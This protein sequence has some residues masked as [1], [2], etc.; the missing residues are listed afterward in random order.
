MSKDLTPERFRCCAAKQQEIDR[1]REALKP[2]ANWMFEGLGDGHGD[3][4]VVI[5]Y[6]RPHGNAKVTWGDLRAA[7]SALECQATSGVT[8]DPVSAEGPLQSG[9]RGEAL[10][11]HL[12]ANVPD[13]ELWGKD[14]LLWRDGFSVTAGKR[15]Q[16][17]PH[18]GYQEVWWDACGEVLEF[19]P[20]HC[21]LY[22]LPPQAHSPIEEDR[23]SDE[24][25]G[26]DHIWAT[27]D[28][29]SSLGEGCA[30]CGIARSALEGSK[31]DE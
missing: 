27:H 17:G 5:S 21:R 7:R 11:W 29:D 16:L 19:D 8:G 20:T 6:S 26:C 9:D 15:I 12:V 3:D 14:W 25:D 28:D 4:E 18:D 24:V 30:R 2:F 13:A 22:P 31:E 1:L 10:H 23:R